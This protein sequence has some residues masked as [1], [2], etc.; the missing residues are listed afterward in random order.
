MPVRVPPTMPEAIPIIVS[1]TEDAITIAIELRRA[2]LAQPQ[3][4][5]FLER[6]LHYSVPTGPPGD[7][8]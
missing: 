3:V 7:G 1:M 5:E 2:S 4:W 6:L 8:E